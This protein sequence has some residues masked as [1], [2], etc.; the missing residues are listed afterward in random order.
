MTCRFLYNNLISESMFTVSS[1]RTGLVSNALKDGSGSATITT[2]GNYFGTTDLEYLVQIDSIAGG[3]EVG[4]ATFKWSDGGGSFDASGVTTDSSPITLNNGVTIA[5]TS[6]TGA[7]FVVGDKWY[8]KGINNF[9]AGKMVDL[10]RDTRYRSSALETPNTILIDFGTAQAIDSFVIYDHNFTSGVTLTLEGNA[11]DAWGGPSYSESVSYA[12][13]KITFYLSSAQTYR[14]F[15]LEVIDAANSD[16]YIE[17]GEMFLGAYFEPA[18]NFS[19]G[20]GSRGTRALIDRNKSAY[21]VEFKRFYNY[22]K[23]FNYAFENITDIAD[24]QTMFDALGSRSAGTV[25]ALFFNEDSESLANT[26][27]VRLEDLPYSLSQNTER[28]TV[29]RMDEVLKSV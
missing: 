25:D 19:F 13:D 26:W 10:N 22:Q 3:A 18:Q 12:A 4:Q 8:F 28:S 15:R 23:M 6:G 21:G 7:D 11:T 1:V 24:F 17:I 16:G 14:Y 2:A 27:L 29:L 5:F 20:S 9:S